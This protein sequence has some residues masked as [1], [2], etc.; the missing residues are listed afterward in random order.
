MEK[1]ESEE[2]ERDMKTPSQKRIAVRAV[3]KVALVQRKPQE[4]RLEE[5]GLQMLRIGPTVLHHF[6]ILASSPW[7]DRN[8]AF[9][10]VGLVGLSYSRRGL[11]A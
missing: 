4:P 10:L 6:F 7:L 11:L 5:G 1:G 3:P 2:R 8:S 9:A